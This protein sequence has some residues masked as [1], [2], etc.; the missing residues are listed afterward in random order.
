[1]CCS[2]LLVQQRATFERGRA[3]S[4]HHAKLPYY[5]DLAKGY[6]SDPIYEQVVGYASMVGPFELVSSKVWC[7]GHLSLSERRSLKACRRAKSYNRQLAEMQ[8]MQD[9]DYGAM[10]KEG[11]KTGRQ[12]S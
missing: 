5:S 10:A 4:Y 7:V 6:C 11:W 1:M 9:R 12:R 2:S 3:N 8:Y